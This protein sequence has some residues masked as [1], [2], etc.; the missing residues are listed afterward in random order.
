MSDQIVAK[1]E[2]AAKALND[3][4]SEAARQNVGI[5]IAIRTVPAQPGR[6]GPEINLVEIIRAGHQEGRKPE[7]LNSANDD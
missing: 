5:S 6:P 2:A 1:V 7:S 4:L 3:A